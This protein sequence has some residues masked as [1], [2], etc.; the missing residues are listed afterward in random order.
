MER[1]EIESAPGRSQNL[2]LILPQSMASVPRFLTGPLERIDPVTGALQ[3]LVLTADAETAIAL[4]ETVLSMTGP[5]GIEL[6]P[7]T[8]ARRAAR[9]MKGRPILAL[10]GAPADIADLIKGSHIQLGGVTSVALAW[11]DELLE[12]DAETTAAVESVMAEIPKTA[13][14][15]VV[16]SRGSSQLDAFVERY[17]RKARRIGD[18]TSMQD[19]PAVPI[20]Y[21]TVST[22]ARAAALRRLLDDLDPPSFAVITESADDASAIERQL[23]ALGY[24]ADRASSVTSGAIAPATHTIILYG[25]PLDSERLAGIASA[26]AVHIIALIRPREIQQ[27][28]RLAGGDARPFTLSAAG[29]LARERERSI[30]R[31]LESVL[32]E[33]V[34]SRE[35]GTLEPLLEGHDGIEIAAAALRLLENERSLRRAPQPAAVPEREIPVRREGRF[36]R[37]RGAAH[38]RRGERDDRGPTRDRSARDK[39]RGGRDRDQRPDWKGAPRPPRKR[40]E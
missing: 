31:E 18:S 27:L 37:P 13:A 17:L 34:R 40:G 20:Q 10:A 3:V 19:R 23:R 16:A 2:V 30:R 4:A 38:P 1:E 8:T 26:G 32:Q 6:F 29:N 35:I 39:P 15:I 14:R 24:P 22:V 9:L 7:V 12:G 21:L 33:G 28:R 11:P 36:D 25:L 5:A